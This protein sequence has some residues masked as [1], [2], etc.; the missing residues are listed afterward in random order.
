MYKTLINNNYYE[1]LKNK[2]LINIAKERNSYKNIF[3]IILYLCNKHQAL[4]SNVDFLLDQHKYWENLLLFIINPREFSKIITLDLCKR[5]DNN[6]LLKVFEEDVEYT[7]DYKLRTICTIKII[8]P[9]KNI[10]LNELISPLKYESNYILPPLLEVI[11]LYNKLYNIEY[12]TDWISIFKTIK[13]LEKKYV[14]Y[15]IEEF[16]SKDKEYLVQLF[17]TSINK[18]NINNKSRKKIDLGKK[19]KIITKYEQV[20]VDDINYIKSL[21]LE[22]ID[23]S[24]YLLVNKTN[25]IL[26][27]SDKEINLNELDLIEFISENDIEIDFKILVTFLAKHI[28]YGIIYKEKKLYLPK[29]S[30]MKKY[31][32]YILYPYKNKIIKKPIVNIYNNTSYELVNYYIIKKNNLYFKLADPITQVRFIYIYIWQSILSQKIHGLNYDEFRAN[33]Q[34]ITKILKY[35]IKKINIYELKKNYIG[36]YLDKIINKKINKKITNEKT[37]FYCHDF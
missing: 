9:Y 18:F 34:N 5:I 17:S 14:F 6:F 8:E 21:L 10:P 15:M 35:Y 24:D 13:L 25:Y 3:D 28:S 23:D 26:E 36:K 30:L 32:I 29:E 2:A 11:D 4:I 20:E 22:F 7:I 31:K 1:Y 27:N 12:T 19:E 33:I 37:N 16:I